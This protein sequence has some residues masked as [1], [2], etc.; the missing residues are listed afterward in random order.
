MTEKKPIIVTDG[1]PE[2]FADLERI[3]VEQGIEYD[4]LSRYN[5]E[6]IERHMS[7]PTTL[8]DEPVPWR[9][10]KL[11]YDRTKT[12][13]RKCQNE[14]LRQKYEVLLAYYRSLVRNRVNAQT[15]FRTQLD[16]HDLL[17][18]ASPDGTADSEV[19]ML[20]RLT[21]YVLFNNE[22]MARKVG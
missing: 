15:P 18:M 16:L 5:Q 9:F 10:W 2:E 22:Y 3:K 8:Y 17:V 7:A 14:G 12:V 6:W 4:P 21:V 19:M 11:C 1:S 13:A 20:H